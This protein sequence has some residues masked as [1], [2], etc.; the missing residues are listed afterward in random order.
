MKEIDFDNY[1]MNKSWWIF[2]DKKF[3]IVS[4]YGFW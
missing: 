2:V 1:E 4:I 3:V